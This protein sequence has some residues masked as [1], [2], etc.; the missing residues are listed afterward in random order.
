MGATAVFL[1]RGWLEQ[2]TPE[3][4]VITQVEQV[5]KSTVVVA[6]RDL[7]FGDQLLEPYLEEVEWPA[8]LVPEGTYTD[9]D[10]LLAE[11]RVVTRQIAAGEPVFTTRLSGENGRASLSTVVASEMRA[12]TISVNDILGVAGFVLPG[13]RV[14][15]QLTREIDEGQ[16]ATEVLLQNVK[17]LGI[18]QNANDQAEEPQVARA[19]TLEVTPYQSQKLVLAS[20]VGTLSLTLRNELDVAAAEPLRVTMA[21]LSTVEINESPNAQLTEQLLSLRPPK[22]TVADGD[23]DG[24]AA[25]EVS[26]T[27]AA[28]PSIEVTRGTDTSTYAVRT[29]NQG[30]SALLDA[31]AAPS[32][33][34]T[35]AADSISGVR[36]PAR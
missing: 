9:I 5:E 31:A 23:G 30:G 18:D 35:G 25:R 12:V 14:D 15:I 29:L 34:L 21:D 22:P 4:V 17:V 33:A 6:K 1:T 13:D 10:D 24:E 11:D 36:S 16:P 8:D 7:F 27:A 2:N 20:Q 26:R 3:P 19:V 32:A 28:A